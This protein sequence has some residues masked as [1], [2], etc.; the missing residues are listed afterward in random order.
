[1]VRKVNLALLGSGY[2]GSKLT[3]EYIDLHKEN[4]NFNF[5]GIIDPDK[6]RLAAEGNKLNL[7]SDR[8]F[9]DIEKCL[10]DSKI[11][12]FHIATNKHV[13]LEK[14]MTLNSRDAFKLARLAEKN[15]C[16]LLVGHIFRFSSAL[17][18]A[19]EII[20]KAHIGDVRYLMLSWLDYLNPIPSR[21][22]I[23][24]LMP[25]PVDILNY[26]LDEW[27][28]SVTVESVSYNRPHEK[29]REDMA[30]AMLEMP[31]KQLVQITLSWIQPGPREHKIGV[32]TSEGSMVIDTISQTVTI[33]GLDE[34]QCSTY[35][36][37]NNTM[38]SMITHFLN[39]VS[40]TDNPNNSALIGAMTVN[41]LSSARR[42]IEE[43]KVV[44][45]LE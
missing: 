4:Q 20:E 26:L 30:F 23:Y 2:W 31:H 25:H 21:D 36:I 8:L 11:D 35:V 24:D 10:L 41:V 44:K 42:S 19:K 33:Y 22:I 6:K 29:L 14:P 45:I 43:K 7:S 16:V 5:I 38:R 32:T 28:L 37:K 17:A 1:M 9:V 13:L 27:A 34:K 3:S 40:G 12:A 15:G 39:C 18:K